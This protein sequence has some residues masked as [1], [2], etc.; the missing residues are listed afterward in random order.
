VVILYTD[1]EEH[2][3]MKA[4]DGGICAVKGVKA[5]GIKPGKMGLGVIVA[6]GNAAGMFTR[7][8]VIAAPLIVT[9]EHLQKHGK[10][11]ALIVNSGNANAFTGEQGLEDAR[12]MAHMLSN[13]LS[14]DP[15]HVAV[16]STGVIGKS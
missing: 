12:E 11:S 1:L 8:K 16:A 5:W 6:E 2:R 7:N 9:R 4:I 15:E 10:L 3:T 13:A 14:I